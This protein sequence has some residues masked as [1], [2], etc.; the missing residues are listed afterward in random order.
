MLKNKI[1]CLILMGTLLTSLHTSA[2]IFCVSN[3]NELI[4]ALTLAGSNFEDDEIRLRG[5]TYVNGTSGFVYSSSQNFDIS[6]TGGWFNLG[7]VDCF[8]QNN[9]PYLSVF[10]GNSAGPN[11]RIQ[12]S[13]GGALTVS[14]L[15]FINGVENQINRGVGLT[16][17][18][19]GSQV[20]SVLIERNV[21][22]N[23]DTTFCSAMCLTT[24]A[25][26]TV[27]NN[28]FAGNLVASSTGV[29][30]IINYS[31]G[32]Y[33]INNTV[34]DNTTTSTLNNAYSGME[35]FARGGSPAFIANNL[36][37]NNFN[38][39]FS[40]R[41]E[42]ATP[43]TLYLYN[44]NYLVALGSYDV[45]LNN[46]NV[47]PLLQGSGSFNY[48]PSLASPMR[49]AG[50]MMPAQ[51]VPPSFETLWDHGNI[52]LIGAARIQDGRVDIGAR[53]ATAESPIFADGFE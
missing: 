12:L 40:T 6:I 47:D 23:N 5:G 37:W 3:N 52:D 45:L 41:D 27:R 16:V 7:N 10:D 9:S 1:T 29:I 42:A 15:S 51:I 8:G 28:V 44:N 53:E 22:S 21:F 19:L 33:F 18:A 13:N 34:V 24:N 36:F 43:S 14:N 26:T 30:N 4:N 32:V 20:E 38:G 49:N 35:I 31:G 39:D 46:I 50:R 25:V 17:D 2:E 48:T 11:L